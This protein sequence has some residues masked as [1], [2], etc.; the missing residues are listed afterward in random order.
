MVK[1]KAQTNSNSSTGSGN[2]SENLQDDFEKQRAQM[3]AFYFV[4]RSVLRAEEVK[5]IRHNRFR[6]IAAQSHQNE[7]A[8]LYFES[9]YLSTLH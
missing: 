2:V 5:M 4:K 7:K 1:G 3:S 8:E 9:L 6:K